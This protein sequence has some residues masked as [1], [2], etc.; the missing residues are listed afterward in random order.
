MTRFPMPRHLINL[1]A[2]VAV[3]ACTLVVAAV[4]LTALARPF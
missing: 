1:A 2:D 3:L 4:C